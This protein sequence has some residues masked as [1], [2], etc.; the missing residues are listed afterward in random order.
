MVLIPLFF[1]G[2]LTYLRQQ[3]ELVLGGIVIDT[4]GEEIE[5][6]TDERLPGGH[7][8]VESPEGTIV[9]ERHEISNIEELVAVL[10]K[11]KS[12]EAF[13]RETLSTL[14]IG[15]YVF[16]PPKEMTVG[17]KERIEVRISEDI[18]ADLTK[19]LKGR[20]TP[21]IDKSIEVGTFMKV[22]LCCGPPGH[23]HPFDIVPLN[24]AE[25]VVA[26]NRITEWAFDVTPRESGNQK[27]QLIITVRIK[28][29][30][31]DEE[32]KDHPVIEKTI[33]VKVNVWRWTKEFFSNNWQWL[34][35]TIIIPLIVFV[36]RYYRN[37]SKSKLK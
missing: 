3:R 1:I 26:D 33:H 2:T 22:R 32:K 18:A 36:W 7:I 9:Y 4:R 34:A 16:N 19:D 10:M 6:L 24:E 8:V 21:Q 29:S 17:E 28:L 14:T 5:I 23:G 25:Q 30:G 35:G 12:D 15:Q 11:N 20:G 31:M 37:Q 27:L 13:V